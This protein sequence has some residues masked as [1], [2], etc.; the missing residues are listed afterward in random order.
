MLGAKESF[1]GLGVTGYSTRQRRLNLARLFKAGRVSCNY[2]RRV[3][4]F[5]LG[6]FADLWLI[7]R[8]SLPDTSTQSIARFFHHPIHRL[9]LRRFVMGESTREE[10]KIAS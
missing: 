4:D 7:F 5:L 10:Q 8:R 9:D 6:T 3:S 1:P 2:V